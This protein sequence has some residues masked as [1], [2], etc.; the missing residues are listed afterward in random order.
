MTNTDVADDEPKP[1]KPK[2]CLGCDWYDDIDHGMVQRAPHYGFMGWA[3]VLFGISMVPSRIDYRCR[4]C[5]VV[6]D[7]TTDPKLLRD[8]V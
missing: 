7:S 8:Q 1:A 5:G 3:A 4:R 6:L 2:G